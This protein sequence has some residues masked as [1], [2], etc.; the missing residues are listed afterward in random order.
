MEIEVMKADQLDD[1]S[2]G[3][4]Q[5][6]VESKK[7]DCAKEEERNLLSIMQKIDTSDC[8]FLRDFFQYLN[9]RINSD[10]YTPDHDNSMSVLYDFIKN[11]YQ[12]PRMPQ[13]FIK[14]GCAL[15]GKTSFDKLDFIRAFLENYGV[16]EYVNNGS[17]IK[18]YVIINCIG[19]LGKLR[20]DC[21]LL[22]LI[23]K[24]RDVPFVIFNNCE[25]LLK[26]DGY[27]VLFKHLSEYNRTITFLTDTGDPAGASFSVKSWYIL[28]GNENK[29]HKT[30]EKEKSAF[31]SAVQ[32]H[33]SAFLSHISVYD[34]DKGKRY[35]GYDIDNTGGFK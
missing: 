11:I 32:A 23:K 7:S 10:K 14:K 5:A 4:R 34:F 33:I 1:F 31:R 18:R 25:N 35:W 6:L 19:K 26:K 8:S 28:L 12:L 24:Y 22:A 20:R 13:S 21:T 15:L 9:D 17:I 30:L 2:Q 27:L 29:I 16:S 3:R